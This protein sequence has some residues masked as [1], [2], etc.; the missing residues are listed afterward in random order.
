MAAVL[1]FLSAVI[2]GSVQAQTFPTK[3]LRLILPFPAGGPTDIVARLAGQ[4]LAEALG[5]AVVIDNRPGGGG[6]IGAAVAAKS[7]ADGHTILLGGITTFGIAP[8][9]HKDLPFDPVRDFAPLTQATRQSIM[10]MVH[11]S[12]PV[13]SVKEY[14]ALAKAQPGRINYASS[15]P[16]GSGHMAGEL[17]RLVTGINI[18]HIP[19]KGAPPALNDLIGGQVQ[20]MFGTMLAAVPH[21]R[22]GRIR[23]LAVTGPQRASAVPEVL[24]F[25]EAGLPQYD[26]SSWNGFLVPAGTPKPVIERLNIELVRILKLPIVQERL[27]SDGADAVPTTPDEFGA[28]IRGEIAKWAKVVKAGG[29]RIE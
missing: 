3:P 25:A 13:K 5:E 6:I 22:S 17:F 1:M 27:A 10:L 24:T 2:A 16:G 19:Y 18:V 26:A 21:V 7:P 4:K 29:I 20:S 14:I 23:A 28:F 15:G 8:S 9:V 12:L 11:P